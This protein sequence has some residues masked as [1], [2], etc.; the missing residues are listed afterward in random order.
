[1]IQEEDVLPSIDCNLKKFWQ[2]DDIPNNKHEFSKEH[3]ACE[4]HFK[5]NVKLL[6]EGRQV[7][8]PFKTDLSQLGT[9]FDVA[10]RRFLFLVK[11]PSKHPETQQMYTEFMKEYLHLKHMTP[12][13]NKAL[14]NSHYVIPHQVLF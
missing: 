8:L 5:E 6:P 11:K 10:K 13:D 3:H 2:V 14:L 4:N 7:R 1:M 9:S 12:V